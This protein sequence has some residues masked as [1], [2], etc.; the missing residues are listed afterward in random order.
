MVQK[1]FCLIMSILIS[2]GK[3][4]LYNSLGLRDRHFTKCNIAG[5]YTARCINT[6]WLAIYFKEVEMFAKRSINLILLAVILGTLILSS[7]MK[8]KA[9]GNTLCGY[10]QDDGYYYYDFYPYGETQ[11]IVTGYAED[12]FQSTFGF[13]IHSG[14]VWIELTNYWLNR[15]GVL[16]GF[17]SYRV[18][19]S[20]APA[21][22]PVLDFY[23]DSTSI[24]AGECTTLYWTANDVYQQVFL[25]ST[26]GP[27]VSG[28]GHAPAS[29]S[30]SV[31]PLANSTYWLTGA[32][33]TTQDVREITIYVIS[34]TNTPI[35][36]TK[37]PVPPTK[38]PIP[39]TKTRIPPTSTPIRPSATPVLPTQLSQPTVPA[40]LPP[41]DG[42][43]SP[44][45]F[46]CF[47]PGFCVQAQVNISCH[48]QCVETASRLRSD[49]SI[50]GAVM[51]SDQ[52]LAIAESK[53]V[54][55]FQNI[56]QQV[57]VREINEAPQSGDI[58]IWPHDCDYAWSGGGHIGYV[59]NGDPFSITDSNWD[60]ACGERTNKPIDIQS[61]MRF[62]TSPYQVTPS[63]GILTPTPITPPNPVIVPTPSG[64]PTDPFQWIIDLFK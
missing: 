53:P 47:L 4:R 30:T 58:V 34:P 60:S 50:W 39:P 46:W 52:I 37:T 64:Q 21:V 9:Q 15:S 49:L 1:E 27:V 16:T 63:N 56:M 10:F 18:V 43:R 55:K 26:N 48:P 20:C 51:T 40:S 54:F 61:C 6:S 28:D 14:V 33:G 59:T 5:C 42:P 62:I 35:P 8:V 44:S 17:D 22:T 41:L 45:G 24:Y 29:G 36:P 19:D 23:V 25:D 38:T 11:W 13:D 3:Q 31:C 2:G 57:R 12:N 32:Y 7:P